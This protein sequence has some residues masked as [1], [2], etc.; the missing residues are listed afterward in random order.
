MGR[1]LA[2]VS[3]DESHLGRRDASIDPIL[4]AS[5]NAR[6]AA[7]VVE[8]ALQGQGECAPLVVGEKSGKGQLAALRHDAQIR[9]S[10]GPLAQVDP[11]PVRVA[12]ELL[13]PS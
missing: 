4:V 5:S 13:T 7:G 11:R 10:I 2:V 8:G 12:I 3:G 1:W 9:A 6:A